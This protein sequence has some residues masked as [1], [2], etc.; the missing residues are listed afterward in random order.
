MLIISITFLSCDRKGRSV[1]G[2]IGSPH[3]TISISLSLWWEN[4]KNWEKF[5]VYAKFLLCGE[6]WGKGRERRVNLMKVCGVIRSLSCI[7][8]CWT[9]NMACCLSEEAKQQKRINQEIE[10]QLRRDKRDARRELKLL[11]LGR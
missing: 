9:S 11:L 10:R 6:K 5:P 3:P 4:N 8:R 1:A 2:W 7:N